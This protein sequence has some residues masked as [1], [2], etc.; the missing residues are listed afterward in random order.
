M[1]WNIFKIKF[2]GKEYMIFSTEDRVSNDW[3][4]KLNEN[5]VEIFKKDSDSIILFPSKVNFY[6]FPELEEKNHEEFTSD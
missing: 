6:G 5:L 3:L 1:I 2:K 4:K